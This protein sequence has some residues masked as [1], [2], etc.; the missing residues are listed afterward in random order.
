MWVCGLRADRDLQRAKV[1][2]TSVRMCRSRKEGVAVGKKLAENVV[3][4][5]YASPSTDK[6]GKTPAVSLRLKMDKPTF[7]DENWSAKYSAASFSPK[8]RPVP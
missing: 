1:A 4:S 2:T 7:T 5:V 8:K 6:V 3:P